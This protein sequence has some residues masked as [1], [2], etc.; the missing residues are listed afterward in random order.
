MTAE[1]TAHTCPGCGATAVLP[2]R[3]MRRQ[4]RRNQEKPAPGAAVITHAESCRHQATS[5]RAHRDRG[6]IAFSHQEAPQ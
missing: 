5:F 1:E 4:M 3:A 6:P 2:N